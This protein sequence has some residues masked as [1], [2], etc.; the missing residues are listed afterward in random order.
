MNM[1]SLG[2]QM[3][4]L[5]IF[6]PPKW[7][8]LPFVIIHKFNQTVDHHSLCHIQHPFIPTNIYVHIWHIDTNRDR[9][10]FPRVM[11]QFDTADNL[12]PRTIW[13]QPCKEDNLTP[14]T[15]WHLGQFDTIMQNRTIWHRP[16][17]EDNLT[18]RTIWH[19]H[20]KKDRFTNFISFRK[21]WD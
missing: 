17:K 2:P 1:Q 13:H 10:I 6:R 4:Y 16:C 15:I 7:L 3:T 9:C 19:H 18:P 8:R 14:R 12:T 20:N 11:G 21:F 5:V